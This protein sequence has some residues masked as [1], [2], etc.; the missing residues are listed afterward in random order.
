MALPRLNESP[1]YELVIPSTKE[2]MAYRPFLVKEQKVLMMA[3]ESQDKKQILNAVLNTIEACAP[4]IN[5]NRLS[6]FDVDYI[7]TQIRTKSVG[8]TTTIISACECGHENEVIVNLENA[9]LKHSDHNDIIK[10]TDE[11]SVKMKWPSYK[12]I[13]DN[14][15][16]TSDNTTKTEIVY[17]T[18]KISIESIMTEDELIQIKDESKEEIDRFISSLTTNQFN[19]INEFILSAPSLIYEMSFKCEACGKDN[20]K[21]LEGLQDFFS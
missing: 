2:K 19:R 6:T 9:K 7:F 18:I 10:L 15:I 11:I 21:T 14:E 17:E 16:I 20:N 8:E 4:G 12:D 3:F 1:Q 13:I 5:K